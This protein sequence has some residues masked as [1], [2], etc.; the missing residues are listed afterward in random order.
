MKA[1][2]RVLATMIAMVAILLIAV[3]ADKGLNYLE[4]IKYEK[5]CEELYAESHA[6][7]EQLRTQLEEL[8][9]DEAAV[10]TFLHEYAVDD[11]EDEDEDVLQEFLTALPSENGSEG[12]VSD[13]ESVSRDALSGEADAADVSENDHAFASGND[14]SDRDFSDHMISGNAVSGGGV[15]DNAIS[16]NGVFGNAVSGNSV[17]DNTVSGNTVSENQVSGNRVSGGGISLTTVSGNILVRPTLRERRL[18]QSSYMETVEW[19]EADQVVIGQSTLD[20]SDKKIAC[21]GDSITQAANLESMEDYQ[22]YSYPTKLAEIL[23]AE[24]VVN[25]GIGGSSI[26]RY[27]QDAF[28][29]RYMDIP[30]DTD[31]ILVMGGTNDGFCL[32]R[33]NVGNFEERSP[34]T[35]IGDLDE[36]MR[37]LKE[38]YPDAEVVFVTPLPNVL[39]D[40]LRKDR[41]ELMSQ[42][43]IVDSMIA[44]AKE[45]EF[46]VIDLYDS[47]LL[48]SHDAAVISNY[49]PDGVHCNPDGYRILAEHIAADL[50]RLQDSQDEEDCEEFREAEGME[51]DAASEQGM[52][53]ESDAGQNMKSEAIFDQNIESESDSA[54]NMESVEVSESAENTGY[55]EV[56]DN[57]GKDENLENMADSQDIVDSENIEAAENIDDSEDMT[58]SR[59]ITELEAEEEFKSGIPTDILKFRKRDTA[60]DKDPIDMEA[61]KMNEEAADA[62]IRK[63]MTMEVGSYG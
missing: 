36:L 32:H 8:S 44:L 30:E 31:L 18:E 37:G 10:E 40:I 24:E 3:G 23:G 46:D 60:Q 11:L 6:Q 57:I 42:R 47:N 61:K 43:V 19:N 21:L 1:A 49:M 26:G 53:S 62:Q 35:L 50:I 52:E 27:W 54:Q 51:T 34:R 14:S 22:Q 25:L 15:S 28:V 4:K 48:D 56:P 29:D 16:E 63:D 12:S 38:N 45:Y 20:F 13:G 17:S 58:D 33:E 9:Q 7:A 59:D 55:K 5:E 39:H 41:P 2:G